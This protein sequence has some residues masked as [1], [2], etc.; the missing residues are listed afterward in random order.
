MRIPDELPD[1]AVH[2][3]YV[4][5]DEVRDEALLRRYVDVLSPDERA[6]HARFVNDTDRHQFLVTRGTIRSLVGRYLGVEPGDCAF[7]SDRYGRPSVSRPVDAAFGFNLSHTRG[8]VACAVAR[9]SEIGVDVEDTSRRLERDLA[10]RFFSAAEADAL[11]ALPPPAR[12]AR[13][14]EYWTLKEAYIKA[15]GLGFSLPLHT[16]TMRI[17]EG[18][19]P[20]IRFADPAHDAAD[21][22]QFAQFRPTARHALAVAVRRRGSDRTIRIAEFVPSSI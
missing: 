15:R 16:F 9:I 4:H 11:D 7:E 17:E 21:T 20:R 2:V 14:F 12:A 8:L 10:R 13:F 6:R 5:S 1:D 18:Q 3:W 22:W 19:P